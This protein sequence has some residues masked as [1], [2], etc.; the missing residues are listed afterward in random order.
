MS[1]NNITAKVA[2]S[3]IS[4]ALAAAGE[5]AEIILIGGLAL[6]FYG[7]PRGTT[8]I[9]AEVRCSE[10]AYFVLT[11]ALA[12]KG[13]IGNIGE[14]ID[15]WGT[16][17]MPAGYR[18][19]AT[20]VLGDANLSVSIL[21]PADYVASKLR[22]G[23]EQDIEDSMSVI[24]KQKVSVEEI[25]KS[26]ALIALPKD[27]ESSLFRKRAEELLKAVSSHLSLPQIQDNRA[28]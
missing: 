11:E 1:E 25:E 12:S 24:E 5:Q 4:D 28:P 17:P 2:I 21:H 27:P 8:D 23:T 9:D 19:R 15:R 7:A 18:E 26:I 16:I 22:R 20:K 10:A 13:I 6:E 14:D 3:A